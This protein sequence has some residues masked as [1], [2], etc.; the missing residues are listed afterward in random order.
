[1][2]REAQ[3]RNL[4][5][6]NQNARPSTSPLTSINARGLS[7]LCT[8]RPRQLI[9][10][11][12]LKVYKKRTGLTFSPCLPPWLRSTISQCLSFIATNE[13][14]SSYSHLLSTIHHPRC[15]SGIQYDGLLRKYSL[16]RTHDYKSS[17]PSPRVENNIE[18][19][20]ATLNPQSGSIAFGLVAT[21]SADTRPG[22]RDSA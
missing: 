15:A 10:V 1:M 7:P 21:D 9:S 6:L 18:D 2:L 11:G 22:S 19:R 14:Y 12:H 16:M 8:C 13:R 3:V 5:C 4:V 20:Y 17:S